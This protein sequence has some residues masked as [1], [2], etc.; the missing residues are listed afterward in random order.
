MTVN[1]MKAISKAVGRGEHR[2]GWPC[3]AWLANA[4]QLPCMTVIGVGSHALR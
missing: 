1:V 3:S 4:A 2:L